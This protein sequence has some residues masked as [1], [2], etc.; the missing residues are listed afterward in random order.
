VNQR[1]ANLLTVLGL[2]G[3]LV[4]VSATAPRWARLLTRPLPVAAEEAEP[5]PAL[6][7]DLTSATASKQPE[8]VKHISVKL[9]FQ[10]PE[11]GLVIEERAVALSG[12][13]GQQLRSA[14]EEL[15]KGSGAGLLPTL[16]PATK[17]LEVFVSARGIAYV[18]LSK[19]VTAGQ[20]GGSEAELITVYSIVNSLTASF[21]SVKR[22]QILVDDHPAPSLAG[23]VDL[24]RPLLPDM[25]FLAAASLEP[26]PA[27][28]LP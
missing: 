23:H 27:A 10:S 24:S 11:R 5:V 26:V 25:T 15:I 18:D 7:P 28:P 4:L 16:D 3:L 13:L 2:L 20:P 21:P 12:D 19:E 9:F 17:V 14:L 22:V 8:A 6:P 1:R